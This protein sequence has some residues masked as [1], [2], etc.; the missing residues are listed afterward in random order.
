[1]AAVFLTSCVSQKKY[2]AA[3]T[4]EQSLLSQNTSL[5]DE[6]VKLKGQVETLQKENAK[7][8]AQIDEW[9]MDS[10]IL[11]IKWLVIK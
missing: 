9:L 10:M 1:M 2:Q 6:I 3:L 5:N 4:R 7:Q 11:V 8:I